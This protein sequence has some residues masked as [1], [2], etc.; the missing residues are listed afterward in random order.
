M[1]G[2]IL[3]RFQRKFIQDADGNSEAISPDLAG[4]IYF[5]MVKNDYVN[6]QGELTEKYYADKNAGM[7]VLPEKVKD[8]ADGIVR[9]LDTI[10]DVKGIMPEDARKNDVEVKINQETL[11][12]KEFQALW[13]KINVKSIYAV[14]F[15]GQELVEKS[16]RALNKDLRVSKIVVNITTGTMKAIKS[17]QDLF[18]ETAFETKENATKTEK[19]TSVGTSVKYDLVGKMVDGTGLTRAT[20]IKILQGMEQTS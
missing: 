3:Q 9:I 20:I 15:E 5:N 1:T 4:K 12:K 18:D 10:Y 14:D 7:L 6:E 16:V 2:K 8:R 13:K 19:I 17:K 11:T